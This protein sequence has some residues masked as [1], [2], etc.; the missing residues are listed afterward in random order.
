MLQVEAYSVGQLKTN[1]YLVFDSQTNQAL[2]ID[3][4]EAAEFLAEK[5]SQK[6]LKLKYIVASHGHFDHVLA[7][8]ILK[9]IFNTPF[10]INRNDEKLLKKMNSS[11]GYWLGVDSQYPVAEI[12]HDLK[13]GVILRLGKHSLTVIETAGH[14]P[15]SVCLSS[16]NILFSGDTLFKDGIGRTD[17]SYSDKK[18]MIKSLDKLAALPPQTVCYPGHG[19]LTT[20]SAM[21]K[22]PN[23][24]FC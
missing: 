15:G 24:L 2:V 23:K 17:Y 16:K 11:A 6:N 10:L 4:G 22:L 9:A 21:K 13:E 19:P 20:I 12:D 3:P 14:T 5:I 8:G 7:A 1:C 18:Q